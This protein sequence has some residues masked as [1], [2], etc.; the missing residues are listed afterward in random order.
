MYIG[1]I[2]DARNRTELMMAQLPAVVSILIYYT[3]LEGRF[4]CGAGKAVLNL[5]VI[6]ESIDRFRAAAHRGDAAPAA[7][8]QLL[9]AY[10]RQIDYLE[11]AIARGAPSGSEL[12]PL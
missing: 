11:E 1:T 7:M 3:I 5:R 10:R 8:D 12:D 4:G 6:D 2:L 9:A